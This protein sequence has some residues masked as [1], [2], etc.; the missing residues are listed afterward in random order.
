[1]NFLFLIPEVVKI[2]VSEVLCS[3]LYIRICYAD[4]KNQ[5]FCKDKKDK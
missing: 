3:V 5:K 1:M 4:L 2:L